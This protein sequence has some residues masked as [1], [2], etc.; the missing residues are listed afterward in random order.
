MLCHQPQLSGA[1][2]T[3]VLG[4]LLVKQD[5]QNTG[6]IPHGL[7]HPAP[8]GPSAFHGQMDQCK[9]KNMVFV[10]GGVLLIR[11]VVPRAGVP[12]GA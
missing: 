11:C 8:L 7:E 3:P 4:K 12:A 1:L 6:C 9:G 2:G 5:I 10:L